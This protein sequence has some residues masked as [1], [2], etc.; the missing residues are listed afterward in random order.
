MN[1]QIFWMIVLLTTGVQHQIR[2]KNVKQVLGILCNHA[3][4]ETIGWALPESYIGIYKFL[5]VYQAY[6]PVDA[7]YARATRPKCAKNGFSVALNQS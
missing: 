2:A 6:K 4:E 5:K 7:I 3:H 1:Y